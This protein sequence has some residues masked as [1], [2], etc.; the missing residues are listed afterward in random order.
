M[1]S[2]KPDAASK[3]G[4]SGSCALRMDRLCPAGQEEAAGFA[5]YFLGVQPTDH[6]TSLGTFPFSRRNGDMW[7][8]QEPKCSN[9]AF[10]VLRA[11]HGAHL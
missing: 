5:R 6:S 11:D 10:G 9:L 4:P 3:S 8:R 2:R 7:N 1:S